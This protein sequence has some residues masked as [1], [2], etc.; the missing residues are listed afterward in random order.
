[1]LRTDSF[2]PV[3]AGGRMLVLLGL[4]F[5]ADIGFAQRPEGPSVEWRTGTGTG[6][7]KGKIELVVL[8]IA[9][10]GGYPQSGCGKPCCRLAWDEPERRRFVASIGLV[11]H[12]TGERWLVDCTPDFRDQLRLFDRMVPPD[13]SPGLAGIL[14]THA[15][16]GH[17]TGLMHLGH[18]AMGAHSVPVFAMPR[19]ARFL[20][21]NGPWRQLVDKRNI[22]LRDI[23]ANR[24]FRLNDRIEVTPLPVP[25]RDEYSETVAFLI[26]TPGRRV[27]YL[28]DIDK[29]SRWDRSIET[30]LRDVDLAFVDGTFFEGGEIPGR[31]MSEIPH[32]FV[33]ESI[34]AFAGLDEA[35]R[36]RVRF[37]H[38]NHTNPALRPDHPA[39]RAIRRAGMG[40]AEQGETYELFPVNRNTEPSG[41]DDESA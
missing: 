31:D 34:L 15:H 22:Q 16:I 37:I 8:G 7:E 27:L 10:D 28:P 41:G 18:E 20:K 33:Q 38:L 4:W 21:T 26:R 30:M 25:H 23:Q 6:T 19:M 17:Y 24:P 9:Q 36:N 39:R 32:P 35:V 12:A 40:V 29:W 13:A 1:M 2:C 3:R 5:L 11:D 14:L